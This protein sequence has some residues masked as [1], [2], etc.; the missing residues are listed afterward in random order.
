MLDRLLNDTLILLIP[1]LFFAF[2]WWT[3]R[4]YELAYEGN[5]DRLPEWMQN[6]SMSLKMAQEPPTRTWRWGLAGLL[7]IVYGIYII[8]FHATPFLIR[9]FLLIA[10]FVIFGACVYYCEKKMGK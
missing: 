10:N 4:L 3:A 1:T 9:L 5:I 2:L 8:T 7:L 6:W